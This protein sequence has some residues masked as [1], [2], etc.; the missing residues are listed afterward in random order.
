[1]L[2]NLSE[3]FFFG[4]SL[5]LALLFLIGCHSGSD[6]PSSISQPDISQPGISQSI[7]SK[8]HITGKPGANVSIKNE[9]PIVLN[10]LGQQ[11]IELLLHSADYP[12]VMSVSLSASSGVTLMD[13]TKPVV[14]SLEE[15]GEYRLP[16]SLN[17]EQ[18]GRHYVRLHIAVTTNGITEK[19]VIA[20][21]I[22]VGETHTKLQKVAPAAASEDVISLP[23]QERVSPLR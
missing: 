20:A 16:I 23:A 22:Q 10:S 18:K 4:G 17:I 2:D 15:K 21:I 19:R 12:G 8:S 6:S 1:M 7:A 5:M 9:Q 13:T 11:S 14:F 3:R